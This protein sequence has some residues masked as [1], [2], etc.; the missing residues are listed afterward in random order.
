MSHFPHE[1]QLTHEVVISLKK[2]LRATISAVW[3]PN[4]SKMTVLA[5]AKKAVF[6]KQAI[7]QRFSK[8]REK[9]IEP[10]QLKSVF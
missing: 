5:G 2:E 6:F 10:R 4:A 8:M 1:S 7:Y 9:D 3:C